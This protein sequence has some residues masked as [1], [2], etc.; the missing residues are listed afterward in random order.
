MSTK[1]EYN[2]SVK[3]IIIWFLVFISLVALLLRF[4][5]QAAEVFLG[6]KQTSGIFVYSLPSDATVYLDNKEVGRTPFEDKSLEAKDYTV[7]ITKEGASWEGKVKL[8]AGTV[9]IVNRDIATDSASSAGEI[10]NLD[11]GKGLTVISNPTE[12]DVEID[13]KS[14]GK[15]PVTVNIEPG[16]HTILVSRPNYLKRSIKADLPEN[17]NLTVSVDLALSEADL[18]TIATP[19]ITQTPEVLVKQTPTGFLRVRDKPS[20]AGKEIAQVKPGDTLILLEE[21]G[22]WYRVRL[23]DGTEGYV[24]SAY[25]EKKNTQ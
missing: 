13:G 19:V 10:L 1:M 16:E 23:S 5:N 3:K 4:S 2:V 8:S 21:M 18:T 7:R 6:I 14:Y 24:S 20:L 12:A 17:F 15:T 9:T 11:K 22:D 25:G